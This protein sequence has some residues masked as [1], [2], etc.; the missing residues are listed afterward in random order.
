MDC[1]TEIAE[2]VAAG[3]AGDRAAF[4]KLVERYHRLIFKIALYKASH[5]SDA[6]DITQDVLLH[7]YRSLPQLREPQA[8]LGW[9]I[10]LTHNRAHRFLSRRRNQRQAM[11]EARRQLEVRADQAMRAQDR[12]ETSEPLAVG[13]LV[14]SLPEEYR[15]ALTWKYLEGHSYQEIGKRLSLSFHQV[16]Y[17]LRRA[18]NALRVAVEREQPQREGKTTGEKLLK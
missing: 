15:L 4:E 8:F 14:R 10:S 11:E 9:L 3:R 5:R 16:D 7:A 17:L 12:A 13:E 1:H 18:K 6:E 2:L